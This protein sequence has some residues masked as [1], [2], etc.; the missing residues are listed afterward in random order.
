MSSVRSSAIRFALLA[1]T[2]GLFTATYC[3]AAPSLIAVGSLTDSSA[4]QY[5]DLSR[6]T[7]PLENGVP[8]NLLGGIGSGLGYVS[9]NTFLAIPDRGPNAVI[10]DPKVNDTTS[11]VNRFQ[12]VT[13]DLSPNNS[14]SG[15]PFNLTPTLSKTTLLWSLSSLIYG[16]GLGLG[17]P[18]GDLGSGVPPGNN[19]LFHYFSGRSDNFNVDSNSGNPLNGRFDPESIR[20]SNDGV[21]IFVSDEYGPYVYQFNRFTGQRTRTFTLPAAFYV[22]NQSP[23]EA[24]E[25]SPYNTSGRVANKGMEGLAITPDGK[26]LV[27][28]MQNSLIQDADKTL[29]RIVT[30][31]IASGHTH[32]YLYQ[33]TTGSGTSE[34]VAINNHEF[35]VDERDG[36][37]RG[38]HSKASVKQLFKIDLDGATDI[39]N[40]IPANPVL[41]SKSLFLDV[42][43]GLQTYFSSLYGTTNS[44]WKY[45]VP[46]KIEGVAFGP[47]IKQGDTTY[48]TLWIAN[49]NDFLQEA[50]FPDP[51]DT[52]QTIT[53]PNSNEFFVFSFTDAD[54]NGSKYVPQKFRTPFPGL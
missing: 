7:Y 10:Y 44:I 11:Y 6:L 39:S 26:T 45:Y 38:D 42:V 1:F 52:T 31:D 12:T 3:A 29:L 18:T 16:D 22:A 47:D 36:K 20:L 48:H 5:T 28:I 53:I 41:V 24:F 33:R 54:L 34:I 13:M 43:S 21:S 51:A 14:G 25:F 27:G 19:F 46:A 9:G 23:D 50:T 4:G 30:I 8:A 49:D 35:L 15:L 17:Y 40:G 37:G 32:Q 2:L